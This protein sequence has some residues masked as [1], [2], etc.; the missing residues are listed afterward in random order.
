MIVGLGP[1]GLGLLA[2]EKEKYFYIS[3]LPNERLQ[4]SSHAS[5]FETFEN[6][7]NN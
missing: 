6:L 7:Y 2:F 1:A 3:V 5:Q 4:R